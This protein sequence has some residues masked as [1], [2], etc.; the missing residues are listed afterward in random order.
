M[1]KYRL[2]KDVK[3]PKKVTDYYQPMDNVWP[4]GWDPLLAYP[5]RTPKEAWKRH[6]QLQAQDQRLRAEGEANY[7]QLVKDAEAYKRRM[8]HLRTEAEYRATQ[9]RPL[10][11][12]YLPPIPQTIP[13]KGTRP[14]PLVFAPK[15]KQ[16]RT[17]PA[18]FN[19]SRKRA[20]Q[21]YREAQKR[22]SRNKSAQQRQ[23]TFHNQL[24]SQRIR[25]NRNRAIARR[26]LRR[27]FV[28]TKSPANGVVKPSRF[29]PKS[30]AFY[31]NK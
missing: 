30:V 4:P 23:Q 18:L 22:L 11:R 9:G 16:V 1:G 19:Q 15:F 13:Q 3:P 28:T 10:R 8:E 14:P 12:P 6:N 21:N 26:R 29:K 7:R 5:P 17:P 27:G 31:K 24:I 20:L 25:A 2:R